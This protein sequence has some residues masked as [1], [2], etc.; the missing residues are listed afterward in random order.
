[1]NSSKHISK[2]DL[3]QLIEEIRKMKTSVDINI[4]IQLVNQNIDNNVRTVVNSTNSVNATTNDSLG[5]ILQN[6]VPDITNTSTTPIRQTTQSTPTKTN[7]S[8]EIVNKYIE[9]YIHKFRY[10]DIELN[11]I[12]TDKHPLI[13]IHHLVKEDIKSGIIIEEFINYDMDMTFIELN[14]LDISDKLV[15]INTI[16]YEIL[17]S[18]FEAI[19]RTYK[20]HKFTKI[21]C[22]NNLYMCKISN[23]D[24]IN[25]INS[26]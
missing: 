1:M 8:V 23:T 24:I 9:C 15:Y 25:I 22:V 20:L 4:N 17:R 13:E 14:I 10:G 7:S 3:D 26:N 12:T 11:Q 18:K 5:D 6:I 19:I 2:D 16:D 21:I